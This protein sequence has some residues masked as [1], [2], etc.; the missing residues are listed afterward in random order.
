MQSKRERV[1]LVATL[2]LLREVSYQGQREDKPARQVVAAFATSATSSTL[3]P[4]SGGGVAP[5]KSGTQP[6]RRPSGEWRAAN[7]LQPRIDRTGRL[8]FMNALVVHAPSVT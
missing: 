1:S 4:G 5:A 3:K 2:C 8:R 6:P 7:R